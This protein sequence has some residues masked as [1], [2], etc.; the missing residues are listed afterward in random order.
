MNCKKNFGFTL[1]E[2]LVV[3]SV[4][5]V[6]SSLGFISYVNFSR[7]QIIVQTIDKIISDLH[8]AQSLASNNQRP[9]DPSNP[10]NKDGL[11]GSY[12][13]IGYSFLIESTQTYSLAAVCGSTPP[14]ETEINTV[15]IPS[16]VTLGPV[17]WKA[18][19]KVLRQGVIKTNPNNITVTAFEKLPREIIVGEGGEIRLKGASEDE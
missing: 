16:V 13:L 15:T 10:S 12:S 14:S 19:F 1:V 5:G 17:G 4:I 18:T 11:C 2:L 3:V 8:L 6:L 9:I 7:T